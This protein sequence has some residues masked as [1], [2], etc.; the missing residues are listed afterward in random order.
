MFGYNTGAKGGRRHRRKVVMTL[1]VLVVFVTT[2]SLILPAITLDEQHAE[3]TPGIETGEPAEVPAESTAA[4]QNETASP[5]AEPKGESQPA[6]SSESESAQPAGSSESTEESGVSSVSEEADMP[7]EEEQLPNEEESEEESAKA[8]ELAY[9]GSDYKVTVRY[10]ADAAVPEGAELEARE[11]QPGTDE[12]KAHYAKVLKVLNKDSSGE[13]ND[14]SVKSTG[15]A[16][17]LSEMGLDL[18]GPGDG[19][20]VSFVRFFDIS[21]MVD[22]KEYEPKDEV[23]VEIVYDEPVVMGEKSKAEVI[24]FAEG[25]TESIKPK[26][27]SADLSN[28]EV[29]SF[30]FKQDSFSVTATLLKYTGAVVPGKYVIIKGVKENNVNKY[31]AMGPNGSATEIH[32]NSDNVTYTD[33]PENCVWDFQKQN[34]GRF[35][36]KNTQ[37]NSWLTLYNGVTGNWAQEIEVGA[38]DTGKTAVFFRNPGTQLPLGW[39]SSKKFILGTNTKTESFYIARL[40]SDVGKGSGKDLKPAGVT[41][42]GDLEKWRDKITSKKIIT[43]KTAEVVDYDNRIYKIDLK[44]SSDVSMITQK[45]D[46]ELI[47]DTS[48][49]MYFPA[50]LEQVPNTAF[51]KM[52]G[53]DSHSLSEVVKR[54]DKN[55]I[56]YFIADGQLATVYALYYSSSGTNLNDKSNTDGWFFVDSSYMNPPDAK[57]MNQSDVINGL[58]GKHIEDFGNKKLNLEGTG[59]NQYAYLYTSPD[60]ITRLAYLKEAVRVASEIVYAADKDSRIGLVTFNKEAKIYQGFTDYNNRQQLYS[61]INAIGLAGGTRQDL[62][63]EQGIQLFGNARQGAQKVAILITDGAPNIRNSSNQQIDNTTAWN[64][65]REKANALKGANSS[66]AKLYTLGLSM[67]MVGGDNSGSLA[68]LASNEDG[69][70][71]HFNAENG[72]DIAVAIKQLI[73]TLV[74]DVDIEGE[75]TDVVDPAFYPV[76]QDGTP[77]QPGTYT[78]NGKQYTWEKINVNGVEQWKVTYKDQRIGHGERDASDN[79]TTPGWQESFYVKAKEDFLG[80]NSIKTNSDQRRYDHVEAQKCIYVDKVTGQ[81]K[82]IDPPNGLSWGQFASPKVNVDELHMT[83]NSTVW[84]VYKGTDVD[85]A[86]QLQKLWENIY[87]KQVVKAGGT[88]ASKKVINDASQKY[89]SK[90]DAADTASPVGV[91]DRDYSAISIEDYVSGSAIDWAS[92]LDELKTKDSVEK[93]VAYTAYGHEPGNIIVKLEKVINA[94]NDAAGKAP[95]SHTADEVGA[96]AEQYKLI[97]TYDPD[98]EVYA[99]VGDWVTKSGED[100]DKSTNKHIINVFAK[101]L[102]ITKTDLNDNVLKGAKFKLYRTARSGENGTTPK[103]LTGSFVEAADIDTSS[104]GI[105]SVDQIDKLKDGEEYYLV[106]TQTPAGYETMAPAKVELTVSGSDSPKQGTSPELF[107]RTQTATLRVVGS[108]IKQTNADGTEDLTGTG[109]SA[110][111]NNELFYFRVPNNPGVE[112]P[113]AGGPGTK[114]MYVMGMLLTAA[115]GGA[116]VVRRRMN[117]TE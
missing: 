45:V 58:P 68:G 106:E 80:G 50:T 73:E 69:V 30:E 71:R 102:Q 75:V 79:V 39:N 82:E 51:N 28:K 70:T 59:G 89:Y 86:E 91:P 95:E 12:Y 17:D 57:S 34:N 88:D 65:I 54:L 108:G 4:D 92:M 114:W 97:V 15:T 13:A 25:G 67:N 26:T 76:D 100:L 96:P 52:T 110:N 105:A 47:T 40:S 112:L 77:I 31:Y 116:L 19:V 32:R 14:S 74:D 60:D 2:Y 49:S 16:D 29:S 43:D 18:V 72:A 20:S 78:K 10:S 36:I 21:I 3:A 8:G 99:S 48:R 66:N 46:L 98:T 83:E 63:L 111:S 38:N 115:A 27:D 93:T 23:K 84:T 7:A 37:N 94:G 1:A 90:K 61:R 53:T 56:Y 87:V 113:A 55:K 85:P 101:G 104:T 117:A 103:G 81:E 11:L 62:G 6:G 35:V 44:A 42:L 9:K 41:S 5:V 24:H 22:G 107:D 64:M 33:I 109:I